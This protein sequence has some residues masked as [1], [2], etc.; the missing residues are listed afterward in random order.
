MKICLVTHQH[1]PNASTGLGR[2][3]MNLTEMLEKEGHEITVITHDKRGGEKYEKKGKVEVRRLHISTSIIADKLLPNLLDERIL[4]ERQLKKFFKSFDL[5]R[6]D[7]LHILDMRDCLFLNKR[8]ASQIP[9]IITANDY[10]PFETS[11]NPFK[12][13][14]FCL[15][16]P[17][18]Y[19]NYMY[20]KLFLP[21][22]MKLADMIISDTK[23]AGA[24][25]HN[26]IKIASEK[27]HAIYKGVDYDTFF[28]DGTKDKYYSHKMLYV[29]SN[30]ERK[31]VEYILK[32]LPLIIEKFPDAK[33]IMIGRKSFFFSLQMRYIVKKY[34]LEKYIEEKWYV[35]AQEIPNYFKDANV[36]VLAPIIED[37]AQ[38]FL[39]SMA[40]KTPVVCTDVDA[41]PEGVVHEETGILVKAKDYKSIAEGVIKI[42]SNPEYARKLGENGRKRVEKMF[43][44]KIMFDETLAVYKEILKKKKR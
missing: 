11:W 43:T 33:L 28:I 4:F 41:N 15:D 10:Y 32:A 17:L 3:S 8:I 20:Y 23:F 38:I 26:R 19:L 1:P 40:T 9:V 42:F 5:S 39:E 35:P 44:K 6:Y 25:I 12:F 21:K 36:F 30:M 24:S 37:L 31:G 7:L 13:P 18:R 29:G 16:L 2:Y 14:Y 34:N 27:I 22:P